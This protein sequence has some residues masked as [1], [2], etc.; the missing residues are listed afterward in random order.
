MVRAPP[1]RVRRRLF[2]WDASQRE[3]K[4]IESEFQQAKQGDAE[5]QAQ[6]LWHLCDEAHPYH[7]FGWGDKRSL[8]ELPAVRRGAQP[9]TRAGRFACMH[10][11]TCRSWHRSTG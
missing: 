4:A 8:V 7:R 10:M 3:V 5:R 2:N 9:R 1:V 6:L 11:H